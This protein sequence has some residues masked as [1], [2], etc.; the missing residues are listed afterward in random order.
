MRGGAEQLDGDGGRGQEPDRQQRAVGGDE[1]K[2]DRAGQPPPGPEVLAVVEEADERMVHAPAENHLDA[3]FD[4][5]EQRDDAVVR[6]CEVACED[7][8]QKQAQEGR[9]HVS[10]A[11]D[12]RVRKERPDAFEHGIV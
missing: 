1:E 6:R 4:G 5:Y 3:G 9:G 8:Q 2:E 11:V 10:E 7:R 12:R